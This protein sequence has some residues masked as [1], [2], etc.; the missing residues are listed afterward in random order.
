MLYQLFIYTAIFNLFYPILKILY[1]SA[2]Y[3]Y[4]QYYPINLK[5]YGSWAVITGGSD[6][7]GKA[8]ALELAEK[9]GFRFFIYV[10]VYTHDFRVFCVVCCVENILANTQ[11]KFPH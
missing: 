3:L 5:E 4:C 1:K 2:K 11:Q 7:I 9:A 8:Y 10:C 6:G